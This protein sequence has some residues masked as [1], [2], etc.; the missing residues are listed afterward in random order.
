MTNGE[1]TGELMRENLTKLPP[2]IRIGTCSWKYDSWKGI[3][4]SDTAEQNYLAEYSRVFN[5]VEVDQWFWSLFDDTIVLPK[6]EVVKEYAA[7]V[8]D[9]FSFTVKVPNAIT[10]THPYAK[11]K[12]PEPNP[13][14]L[15]PSLF[16]D[17]IKQLAPVHDRIDAF[18]FQFEYLNK[19]KMPNQGVFQQQLRAFFQHCPDRFRYSIEIRNPRF[20]N[21]NYFDFLTATGLYPVF[22]QGYWM[23]PVWQVYEQYKSR[24][25]DFAL[26]RLM[27]PDRSNIEQITKKRWNAVVLPKDAELEQIARMVKDLLARQVRI[28]I[29][30][31]NHYE[32]CAPLTI[33]R[34]MDMLFADSP[35][36]GEYPGS[37]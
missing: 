23:P 22:V 34:F 10:L 2:A 20:L 21:A 15:S 24:L 4:Y 13:H 7:S 29:S 9:D 27:G 18:I 30:V 32:G 33:D 19:D 16:D 3:V 8:P 35:G 36:L 37:L 12:T 14:F 25:N 1:K 26:I 17:F 11:R 31:N 5:S 28:G 6:P